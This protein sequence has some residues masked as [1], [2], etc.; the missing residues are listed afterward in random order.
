MS[1]EFARHLLAKPGEDLYMVN[2]KNGQPVKGLV[3]EINVEAR[4]ITLWV[5]KREPEVFTFPEEA[6]PEPSLEHVFPTPIE[7]VASPY[8]TAPNTPDAVA[9]PVDSPAFPLDTKSYNELE[10]TNDQKGVTP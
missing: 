4:T 2:P 5:S 8:A 10:H 1:D 6:K 7:A 3:K 9:N